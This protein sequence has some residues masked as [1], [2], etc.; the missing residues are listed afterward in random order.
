MPVKNG[1]SRFPYISVLSNGIV[2]SALEETRRLPAW[3]GSPLELCASIYL[4]E[5]K[6]ALMYKKEHFQCVGEFAS[7]RWWPVIR[8]LLASCRFFLSHRDRIK[9]F[10]SVLKPCIVI[11]IPRRRSCPSDHQARGS[12]PLDQVRLDAWQLPAI[13]GRGCRCHRTR[14]LKRYKWV[15]L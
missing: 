10:K 15:P 3:S 6:G 11:V 4:R 5:R 7:C 12:S 8:L 9:W 14:G 1:V 13:A 2:V